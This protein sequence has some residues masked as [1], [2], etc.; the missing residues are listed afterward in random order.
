MA[1]LS[2]EKLGTIIGSDPELLLSQMKE[3]GLTHSKL[4]DEVTDSDKKTLLDFL[5]NQ[6]TKTTK[7]ISLNKSKGK[8]KQKDSGSVAITRKRVNRQQDST[9]LEEKSKKTSSSINFD[10]IEKKRLAGENQKKIDEEKRKQNLEQ[11]TLVTRRKIKSKDSPSDSREVKQVVKPKKSTRQPKQELTKKEQRELEGESFL[12]NIEKQEFEKPSEFISKTIKIPDSIT[13]S[14]LAQI[15]SIKGAEL[16]KKLMSIGVMATLN[17]ALDQ[18]TAILVTEELGHKG[19]PAEKIKVED[20]LMELVTYEGDEEKRNPVVS[21]LGHVDHG[22]TTLLDYIRKANVA[23]G[24]EGGITQKIGAYQANTELGTI[25]FIDTP[26]H[27]AFSEVRARGANSTDIVILVVAA[28]DGLQPQTEEAIS[29]AR[30]AEVPI[31][32]AVNK[33]DREEADIEKVKTELSNKEL[34]PED[35]GGQTQF[36]PISALKGDGVNELLEAVSLEAEVLELKA[37][38]KGPAFG[39]VLDSTTEMGKGAVAT[40]LVQKGTLRK[41]DTILVGDQTKKVRSLV[42]ENG[43]N[44]VSAGPSVPASITGLDQPPKAGEEFIV[45]TSEKMAKEISTERAEKAREERL[46]RNQISNLEMLFDSELANSTILNIVI[47]ADTHGSL[48][49]II[50][51]LKNLESEEVK[52]NLVHESVG[53]INTNDVNLALTTNSFVIGFNVRADSSAK[54]LAEKESIEILYYGII[55]DLIDGIKVAIEG[56]LQPDVK[57]EILGTAEVKDLFKSPKFGLIA[58]SMVIEGTIKRNRPIRVLR[59]DIVIFEGELDSLK[60]FKDDINEVPM[61]TECGI[62]VSNYKDVQIGDK[63]E[64]FERIV[65]KRTLD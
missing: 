30:A 48:E 40:I 9:T 25:A 20:R 42:D 10:E 65:V 43:I 21:V 41:G 19:E 58:G 31:V 29:H 33:I 47:K 61:G 59:D 26:G 60:R 4:S 54:K 55:Y 17:Q 52:I 32:V 46:A 14:E 34:I 3:A 6:Q 8:I 49:A 64:V 35:W 28:D 44:L 53:S 7:T 45:V 39:I 22:K 62:G 23:E 15:L 12:S 27:A 37:H 56:R 18:D 2:V 24:E 5:K 50:G 57:E 13:V 38:H 63:I 16:V 51:S 1:N 11:K 36:I